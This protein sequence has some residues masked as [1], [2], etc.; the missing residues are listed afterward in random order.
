M[1]SRNSDFTLWESN[2]ILE[3][4]V[5]TYDKEGKFSVTKPEEKVRTIH[6]K[7]S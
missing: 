1:W 6:L 5:Y 2:A 7:I 4:L 3:Y